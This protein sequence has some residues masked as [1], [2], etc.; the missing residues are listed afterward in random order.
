MYDILHSKRGF[1]L[2]ELIVVVIIVGILASVAIPMMTGN[3][4]KAR[5]S[6]AMAA[7]GTF[8]TAFRLY[9]AEYSA[10]PITRAQMDTYVTPA[11]LNGRY[12]ASGDY[13]MSGNVMTATNGT[14]TCS[15]DLFTGVMGNY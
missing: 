12:Y 1:T 7:L 9:N 2:V 6:E 13:T 3:V 14:R 5:K 10:Y 8:R 11:D 15:M 4:E